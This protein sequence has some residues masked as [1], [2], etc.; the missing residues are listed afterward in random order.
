[1]KFEEVKKEITRE[2]HLDAWSKRCSH[3][4]TK[5]VKR[6]MFE[7]IDNMCGVGLK[8]SSHHGVRETKFTVR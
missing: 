3:H 8:K 5:I 7:E 1:M 4:F 2:K 6:T